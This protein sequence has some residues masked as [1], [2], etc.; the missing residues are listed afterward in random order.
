MEYVLLQTKIDM[1]S[2]FLFLRIL[3][4]TILEGKEEATGGLEPDGKRDILFTLNFKVRMA[5]K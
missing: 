3:P 2:L 5:N 4:I 1:Y